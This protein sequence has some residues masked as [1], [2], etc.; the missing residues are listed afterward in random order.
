MAEPRGQLVGGARC[1]LHPGSAAGIWHAGCEAAAHALARRATPADYSHSTT[2]RY[3]KSAH[4]NRSAGVLQA[5]M[6]YAALV[7][8]KPAAGGPL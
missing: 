2:D 8:P 1:T 6:A 5:A 7:Q 4:H 3:N